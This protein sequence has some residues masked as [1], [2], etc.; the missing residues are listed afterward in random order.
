MPKCRHVAHPTHFLERLHPLPAA[1]AQHSPLLT[2]INIR[3]RPRRP[4]VA[5]VESEPAQG[6]VPCLSIRPAAFIITLKSH[7]RRN[8][9]LHCHMF[10]S[11]H[12]FIEAYGLTDSWT[13]TICMHCRLEQPPPSAP[14]APPA[15]TI[16]RRSP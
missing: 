2:S 4:L 13:H 14:P 10:P 11:G 1:P 15:T 12:Y 5:L 16:R 7:K 8:K 6:P 9:I 3:A